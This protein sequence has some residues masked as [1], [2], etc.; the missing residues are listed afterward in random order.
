M[1]MIWIA[2]YAGRRKTMPRYPTARSQS[3]LARRSAGSDPVEQ[4]SVRC[5][6]LTSRQI[7]GPSRDGNLRNRPKKIPLWLALGLPPAQR[8]Q[9]YLCS[10]PPPPRRR[11][12][13][14]PM[15]RHSRKIAWSDPCPPALG[16]RAGCQPAQDRPSGWI[17][18]PSPHRKWRRARKSSES[19]SP[20]RTQEKIGRRETIPSMDSNDR[21][22]LGATG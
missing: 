2:L 17:A 5:P 14:P 19:L 15:C 11:A 16:P 18:V 1:I 21:P 6:L 7:H 13:R 9:D 12:G 22:C 3:V 20:K 4:E 10:P 8:S